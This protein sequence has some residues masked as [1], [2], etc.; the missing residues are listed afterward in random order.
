[1]EQGLLLPRS[2]FKWVA[3]AALAA[4]L[5]GFV[6]GTRMLFVAGAIILLGFSFGVVQS[7]IRLYRDRSRRNVLLSAVDLLPH[8]VVLLLAVVLLCIVVREFLR[9]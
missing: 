6:F 9:L 2:L 7:A 4:M 1:M 5:L 3:V 8:G